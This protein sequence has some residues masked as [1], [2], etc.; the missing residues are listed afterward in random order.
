MYMHNQKMYINLSRNMYKNPEYNEMISRIMGGQE[1][2]FVNVPGLDTKT[3][4]QT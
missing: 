2:T 3:M 1:L 4:A